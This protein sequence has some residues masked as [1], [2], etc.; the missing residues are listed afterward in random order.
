MDIRNIGSNGPV[1][2]SGDRLKRT[3]S[4][5]AGDASPVTRD[6]ATISAG[7]RE[8]AAAVQGLAE[9][10]KQDDA[11]REVKVAAAM[12]KLMNGELNERAVHAATAERLLDAKFLTV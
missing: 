6:E 7:S 5:R 12:K 1:E 2:R 11:G 4:R 3:E 9:R 10:S 8:T